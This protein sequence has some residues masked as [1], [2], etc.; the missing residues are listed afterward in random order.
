MITPHRPQ[1]PQPLTVKQPRYPSPKPRTAHTCVVCGANLRGDHCLGDLCCD[2]HPRDGGDPRSAAPVTMTLTPEE[3]LLVMLY[4]AAPAPLNVHRAFGCPS[5]SS[6]M[7]WFRDA[8]AHIN[9]RVGRVC[10]HHRVGYKFVGMSG[11]GAVK[12]KA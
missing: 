8:V 10:G 5:T 11:S 12:V 7:T 2:A 4:R 6:N 3:R 1:R 9:A